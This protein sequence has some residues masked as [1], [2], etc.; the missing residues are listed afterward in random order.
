MGPWLIIDCIRSV[1]E[2]PPH[3]ALRKQ[4]LSLWR[5]L[6]QPSL[7]DVPPPSSL[8]A[9]KPWGDLKDNFE[10]QGLYWVGARGLG[11]QS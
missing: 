2:V 10:S 9:G 6:H 8:A 7:R 5:S 3:P 11:T 1:K 4:T